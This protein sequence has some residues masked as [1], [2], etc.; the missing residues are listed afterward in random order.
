MTR[1]DYLDRSFELPLSALLLT[2]GSPSALYQQLAQKVGVTRCIDSA[3]EK[4]SS[5][6]Q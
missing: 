6:L 4:F 2:C 1:H 5:V 3:F